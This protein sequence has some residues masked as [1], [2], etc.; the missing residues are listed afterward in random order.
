[1]RIAAHDERLRPQRRIFELLDRG[2][3][4]IEIEVSDD[5]AFETTPR[6]GAFGLSGS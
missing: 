2:I 4:G 5:H 6:L 1:M 3:E